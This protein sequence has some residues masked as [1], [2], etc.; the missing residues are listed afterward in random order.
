MQDEMNESPIELNDAEDS[1]EVTLATP[2]DR[3]LAYIVDA[4]IF[5]AIGIV[6][7]ILGFV[8]ALVVAGTD[9]LEKLGDGEAWG[10]LALII[11]PAIILIVAWVVFVLNM[12][13]RDGQSPGKKVLKIRIVSTD[14]SGWGWRG[15][16]VRELLSKW[17]IVTMISAV[18]GAILGGELGSDVANVTGLLV[19]LALFI[20]II[21]DEN[22]QTLQDKIANTYV[23]KVQ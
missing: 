9:E 18:I 11:L 12:V 19:Q 4:L 5:I 13:A 2:G 15:T 8:L 20:W 6:G 16:I 1:V 7:G 3:L 14:G 22:N 17:V 10:A 23:V 21:A